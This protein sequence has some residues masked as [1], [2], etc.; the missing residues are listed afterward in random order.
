MAS[1]ADKLKFTIIKALSG[2]TNALYNELIYTWLGTSII[3]NEENDTTYIKEG[4][5]RNATIYSIVNL[6]TRTAAVIPWQVYRVTDKTALK[7]YKAMSSGTIDETILFKS[8]QIKKKALEIA[9]GTKLEEV[10]NHPNP[11]QSYNDFI[12]EV[13]GFGKLTGNR[14]IYGIGP[15]SGPNANKFDELY[16]LPSNL[17]QIESDG[18][19]Q[20]I[21]GYK[22]LYN[23][24]DVVA[25]EAICHIKDFNP[26]YTTAG[27][28]LYG[29]SPLR[30]GLK[31]L[32]IN[33]DAENA[34]IRFLQNG[35]ARG[36]LMSKDGTLTKDQADMLK[37][38]LRDQISGTKNA[39][40]IV[41]SPK[42]LSWVNFGLTAS[43]MTLIEQYNASVKD[44]CNIY[45]IPVQLLNNTDTSTYNNMKEAKKA[46]YQ[47]AVIPELIKIRDAI[48]H[49]LSPQYG[50][51]LYFDYDFTMIPELQE[52]MDKVVKQMAD[53]WWIT[54]N[55]KREAM[56]YGRDEENDFMNDYFIPANLTPQNIDLGIEP[57]KSF[58]LDWNF[59]A[60]TFNDYPKAAS[61]NAQ[62]MIDW[63]D[64]YPDEIRGGTQVGWTRARQLA[65]RESISRD[66]VSRMAQFNRHR[67]N[68]EVAP[69]Y[70][71]TPWKDAGYV[72]WNLWGGTEGVDWA[73]RKMKE[74]EDAAS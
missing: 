7:N 55:E 30:A 46:L 68:A 74:L 69:E 33:N 26:D 59:K 22:I 57:T 39:G 35:M 61:E 32:T 24:M 9:Y 45:G 66:V 15:D 58:E 25:P 54:P 6:I 18:I 16:V 10:L 50:T 41:I 28:Q 70:K 36:M 19:M 23:A 48:N 3:L 53:A 47:N 12:Q 38:S 8:S 71:E 17:V 63:K 20:P 43:D 56:Y 27:T 64:K 40:N 52:E 34:G 42:D 72:A 2:Q 5:Q 67:E 31:A 44:L 29:Q 14:F 60:D 49:W 65:N 1:F 62:K 51:D 4:Y 73:I 11:T 13:I 37:R 21:A